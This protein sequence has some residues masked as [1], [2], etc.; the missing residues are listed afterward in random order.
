MRTRDE[1]S[2]AILDALSI[3]GGSRTS[4]KLHLATNAQLV[5]AGYK[6]VSK[7]VYKNRLD[8]LVREEKIIRERAPGPED[9][10]NLAVT[11]RLNP[12]STTIDLQ[13]Q[14]ND[15]LEELAIDPSSL[16]ELKPTERR[17]VF[18]NY[19]KGIEHYFRFYA[20]LYLLPGLETGFDWAKVSVDIP[21]MIKALL[22]KAK[23]TFE[24]MRDF[25]KDEVEQM[26]AYL[27]AT[28]KK[29]PYMMTLEEFREFD[30]PRPPKTKEQKSEEERDER[31]AGRAV[32]AMYRV[33]AKS[34]PDDKETQAML[35]DL[36]KA[37]ASH[38]SKR[39]RK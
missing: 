6:T 18:D 12:E 39:K 26:M 15:F 2:Q 20:L 5:G 35:K 3:H 34:N 33:F 36:E 22:D 11:Y 13:K 38:G 17:L 30:K 23:K 31:V 32:L 24:L 29:P 8:R 27:S 21:S 37:M 14:V 4:N 16:K 1:I 28:R 10:I 19:L 7:P 25:D 9:V